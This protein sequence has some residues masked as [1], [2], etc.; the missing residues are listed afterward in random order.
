MKKYGNI[1]W[2]PF[3]MHCLNFIDNIPRGVE[4][5]KRASKITIF[6]YNHIIILC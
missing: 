4:L 1:Y 5:T 3:A 2:S 6:I